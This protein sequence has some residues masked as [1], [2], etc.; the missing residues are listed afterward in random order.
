[1]AQQV[2]E[3]YYG[4]VDVAVVEISGIT[5]TG[6]LIPATSIGNNKTWL[7]VAEKVILEVNSWVPDAM[8]G[9]HD[10][11]YGTALP[12]H[13]KPIALTSVADR[14]GQPYFSIDPDRVVAVVETHRPDSATPLTAP[15]ATSEAI[16]SHV[17]DFFAH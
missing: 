17:L 15:D 9:V 13:R 4:H 14:I 8:D 16:A 6:E 2:W 7:E 3:G 12:P 1:V 5:D 10:V 11:Y